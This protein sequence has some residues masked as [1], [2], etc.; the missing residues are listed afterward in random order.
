MISLL[1]IPLLLGAGASA[2]PGMAEESRVL[3][4]IT[5]TARR[6]A[7]L[8]PASSYASMATELRFDPQINLQA[9]GL[10]E[11]QSDI[12]VRGGLFEN[13]G[14]R[15]GTVT[16]NDPQ[17][18]HYA[19]EIP[20]DPAMLSSP[21]ILTDFENGLNSF[22]A[23][24]ATVSY[25]F[26]SISRGGSL[27]AGAGTDGLLYGTVRASH[28]KER[29]GTGT[30]GA[31]LSAS[32]SKGDGTLPYGDHE[33]KRFS[34]Q[35]Q[36]LDD[37]QETNLLI[38]YHDKFTGWPGMYT[39]FASLPE[40]DHTK[41]GLLVVDHRWN[42]GQGWWSIGS[43][44]RWLENDYDFDRR[45]QESGVPGSFEHE[46]RNFSLALSGMQEWAGLDWHINGQFTADRLV[47]STDLTYGD[48]N[49]RS[50]GALGIAPGR[51][52]LLASGDT[53][54][55]RAGLRADLSNRDENALS[56][57]L[58]FSY[59]RQTGDGFNRYDIEYSKATQ[60]P[61]Y[62]ALKSRPTGLFGG[63]PD[64]GREYAD[65]LRVGFSRQAGDWETS[66]SLFRRHDDDLVD[67]TF[68]QG[69]PSIR[70]A[71]PVDIDVT[72]FEAYVRWQSTTL[73]IV[74]GYAWL[75]KDADYGSAEV[76]A[77]YYALNFAE[78]RLTL[79]AA[80][81]PV[82]G[83]EFRLDNEYRVHPENAL[84]SSRDSAYL[85]SLSVTWQPLSMPGLSFS[86][87]ADNLTDSDFQ[88]FPGTPPMGR[89][90]SVAASYGW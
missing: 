33:F 24:V 62:T 1:A 5:V 54:S 14:F 57:L 26:A 77:S 85:A 87:I 40:T 30:F 66:A 58:M 45:T 35:L 89:A 88:E 20:F 64:L 8:Q 73:D 31:M 81:Q 7:N 15:L 80:W 50:Y 34:G 3:A 46:T 60:L 84:R 11:G 27:T 28:S 51:D 63:N 76:D 48:F 86:A 38:G 90:V 25:G 10:P 22:N 43:A 56:P 37:Q 21:D 9:R 67:W 36:W 42:T 2:D 59:S 16:V 65:T 53:A 32:A 78:H 29:D 19:V 4:P 12:T 18:G 41:L 47:R 74:G 70:Q 13:T 52:W 82:T 75:D 44:Y 23:S 68:S 69:A 72:G 79:A 71:N 61:G 17:T 39:G 55:L 83:W 6:V 49:S